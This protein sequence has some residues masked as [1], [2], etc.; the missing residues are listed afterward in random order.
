[1]NKRN[2]KLKI[3]TIIFKL[4]NQIFLTGNTVY[5]NPIYSTS[6]FCN[7]HAENIVPCG[8]VGFS[9]N[10]FNNSNFSNFAIDESVS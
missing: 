10:F 2:I 9:L 7:N 1:M 4:S 3:N 6:I 8:S 5:T